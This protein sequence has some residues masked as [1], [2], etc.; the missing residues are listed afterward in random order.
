MPHWLEAAISVV[1]ALA[2]WRWII[3]PVR[4]TW[5]EL[6]RLLRQIRDAS[7]GVQRLALQMQVLSGSVVQLSHRILERQQ[8]NEERLDAMSELY[9]DLSASVAR[10]RRRLDA[11]EGHDDDHPDDRA[12][13]PVS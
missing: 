11:L 2:G 6:L 10:H 7:G 8:A 13:E 9:V 5:R 4:R 1:G 12:T 3:R